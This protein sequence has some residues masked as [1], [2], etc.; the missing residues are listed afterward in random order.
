M[1][2]D[3]EDVDRRAA[4]PVDHR[5]PAE[6][7]ADHDDSGTRARRLGTHVAARA[8]HPGPRSGILLIQVQATRFADACLP[9]AGKSL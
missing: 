1:L 5:Q 3:E 7:G 8:S 6:A 4:Q 2:V 9:A